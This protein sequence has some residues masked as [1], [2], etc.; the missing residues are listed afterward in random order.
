MSENGDNHQSERVQEISV[1]E[2]EELQDLLHG[3]LVILQKKEGYHFSVDP[4]L[5]TAFVEV[6]NGDKVIDLGVGSGVMPLVLA[7]RKDVDAKYVGLEV[8]EPIADMA[9]RSVAANRM[10]TVVEIH[11][12]DIRKVR[13]TY[14]ADSFDVAISNPPYV[15]VQTGNINP[16][17]ARALARH[18]V[19]VRLPEVV[20]AAR[21]LVK[22][23]GRVYFI[24]P[25]YRLIDLLVLCREQKLEPRRI[26]F[27]HANQTSGAKLVM[28]ETVRDAGVELKV[29]KPLLVYNLEGG[30]TEEVAEILNESD[31]LI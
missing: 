20:G 9:Q 13:E 17:D 5:L 14:P 26:R 11:R 4:I 30:Y 1:K 16:N 19:L 24:Y 28:V 6:K 10:E 3:E 22:S 15:P 27:I 12:G 29:L 25:A 7:A 31:K 2:D 8:Q 21:Y 18:E 23:K